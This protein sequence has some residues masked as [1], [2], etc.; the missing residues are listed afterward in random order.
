MASWK[1][2]GE[3]V[4]SGKVHEHLIERGNC[5]LDGGDYCHGEKKAGS[6]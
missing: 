6:G 5:C 3:S 1:D 2:P 4:A